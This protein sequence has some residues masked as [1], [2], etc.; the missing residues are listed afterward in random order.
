MD[1]LMGAIKLFAGN[2]APDNYFF[3]DGRLLTTTQYPAL[4]SILG[5]TYGGNGTTTFALPDLRSRVAVG[6]GM[7]VSPTTG[8]EVTAG[9]MAGE[10]NVLLRIT[11][12]P[13]HIHGIAVSNANASQASATQGS[14]IATP[15]AVVGRSFNQTLGFNTTTPNTLLNNGTAQPSGGGM[16]HNNMQPYLGL[17][18]IICWN[19]VYPSRP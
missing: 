11:E 9:E 19:G 6:G 18:Y 17:S 4:F 10:S 15:V 1:E 13:T 3:C 7:G 16:P 5:T 2:F 8:I 14:T 12:M